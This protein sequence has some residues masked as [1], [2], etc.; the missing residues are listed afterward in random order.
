MK[1]KN[2]N[3]SM[4]E[5][6]L[7][8]LTY[9]LNNLNAIFRLVISKFIEYLRKKNVNFYPRKIDSVDKLVLHIY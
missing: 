3:D 2:K 7:I 4:K 1:N 6:K 5:Y 9:I 8:N